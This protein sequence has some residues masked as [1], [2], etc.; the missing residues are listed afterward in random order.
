MPQPICEQSW[1]RLYKSAISEIDPIKGNIKA[2]IAT[3]AIFLRLMES[4]S[5]RE[6]RELCAALADLRL[7]RAAIF[8]I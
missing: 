3:N 4:K 5:F 7:C 6:N 8:Q 2:T 1:K